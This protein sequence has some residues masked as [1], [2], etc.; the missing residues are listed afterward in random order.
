MAVVDLDVSIEALLEPTESLLNC[1]KGSPKELA[2]VSF[3]MEATSHTDIE[4]GPSR[5]SIHTR[6]AVAIS[7]AGNGS[8]T[9]G[10]S[11]SET[12]KRARKR[13]RRPETW[14]KN[15]AKTKRAKGEQYVSPSTGKIVPAK[16]TVNLASASVTVL[17]CLQRL[18]DRQCWNH[19]TN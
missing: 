14:K 9:N 18:S 15:V 17:N 16:T 10:S 6:V 11:G 2:K 13:P 5:V 7:S 1:S 12:P 3:Q 4:A 19:S 8:S